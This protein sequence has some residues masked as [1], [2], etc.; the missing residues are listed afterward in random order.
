VGHVDQFYPT[1]MLEAEG[2]DKRRPLRDMMYEDS[3][4]RRPSVNDT[5][6]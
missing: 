5:S 6:T 1:P 4:G 2:W 3:W